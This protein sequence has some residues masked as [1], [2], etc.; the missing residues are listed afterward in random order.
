MSKSGI[1][2]WQPRWKVPGGRPCLGNLRPPGLLCAWGIILRYTL[3]LRTAASSWVVASLVW[4]EN[5]EIA[6]SLLLIQPEEPYYAH[7]SH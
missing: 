1:C 5:P 3:S 7:P 6:V 4:E 2:Q